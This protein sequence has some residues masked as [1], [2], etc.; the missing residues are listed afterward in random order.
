MHLPGRL[1]E[2]MGPELGVSFLGGQRAYFFLTSW[3]C[4]GEEA[5]WSLVILEPVF[6]SPA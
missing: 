2:M 1:S 3:R 5:A 6:P 4:C